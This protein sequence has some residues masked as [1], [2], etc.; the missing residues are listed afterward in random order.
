MGEGFM[1]SIEKAYQ[2]QLQNIQSKTGKSLEELVSIVKNSGLAKHGELRDMLKRELGLGHGDANT[3]VHY[4]LQS[5][6]AFSGEAEVK[7]GSGV[8]DEIYSGAKAQLRPIHDKLMESINRFGEF[9]IAPKK[10]YVS[11][12]RKKQFAMI[13]PASNTRVELGVN[14]KN[15]DEDVRL[16][17][18]PAG[19]MCNY[20]VKLT[21]P[22][23][24]DSD[25]VAWVKQAYE[26][27]G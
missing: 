21:N 17:E 22:G 7:T 14:V 3:L 1:S 19:S 27:A 9:E 4:A 2:T 8:L 12:R 16:I 18:L 25:V 10:G 5:I 15:L 6:A 24:V 20:K 13:G 23:E 11:L 26:S